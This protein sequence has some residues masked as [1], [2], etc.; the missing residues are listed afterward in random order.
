MEAY[1]G[2]GLGG[3]GVGGPSVV[4]DAICPIT[5]DL[6][7]LCLTSDTCRSGFFTKFAAVRSFVWMHYHG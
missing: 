5:W 3:G 7:D 1:L 2:K 4:I 6:W